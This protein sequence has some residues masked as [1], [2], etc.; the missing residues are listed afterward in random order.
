MTIARTA[1]ELDGSEPPELALP[2]LVDAYGGRL[3]SLGLRFC[4]DRE[5]ARD[6]VQ[7]TFLAAF[8]SW[9]KFE[10]RSKPSTWLF[11][12]A[13][14]VCRR[15]HRLRSGEPASKLSLDELVPLRDERI[16][17]LPADAP[18]SADQRE[19]ARRDVERAI[20]SLPQAFRMPLVL[21]EVAGLS[22]A[23]IA[24]VLGLREATVKTRLH[25]ARLR[26]RKALED[27]LPRRA[28]APARYS[29]E[30]CLDLLEAKQEALDKGLTFAFPAGVVCERCSELFATLD[31]AQGLCREV[32]R[33]ALPEDLRRE[34]LERVRGGAGGPP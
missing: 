10:G 12:I 17:A 16:A 7:E 31:L 25:R 26:V 18:L 23:E 4:G 8:R 21:K 24:A 5:D 33:G 14:R 22:L 19:E 28:V 2:L 11:T 27:A 29:R 30:V 15:M 1:D 34:L 3:H 20:A 6:L 13:A 32:E 9:R